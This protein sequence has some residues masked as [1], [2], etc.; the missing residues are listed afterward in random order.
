M[1]ITNFQQ[2]RNSNKLIQ[3]ISFSKAILNDFEKDPLSFFKKHGV[4]ISGLTIPKDFKM[5][6]QEEINMRLAYFYTNEEFVAASECS[7]TAFA[8]FLGL[9][10]PAFKH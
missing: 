10:V 7:A 6:S 1:T 5:P 9:L 4:D 3:E 2:P 8:A